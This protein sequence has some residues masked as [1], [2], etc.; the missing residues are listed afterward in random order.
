MLSETLLGF[1]FNPEVTPGEGQKAILPDRTLDHELNPRS[2][3]AI[4]P[5]RTLDYKLPPY[6]RG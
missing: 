2:F 5:D 1:T 3:S 4:A 6:G